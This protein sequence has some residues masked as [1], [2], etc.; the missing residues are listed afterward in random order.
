[1]LACHRGNT[2]CIDVLL[3]DGR[4]EINQK[5]GRGTALHIVAHKAR[6]LL[7]RKLLD[8]GA[9]P[10]L[11]DAQGRIPLEVTNCME[12]AE[13]IPRFVGEKLMQQMGVKETKEVPFASEINTEMDREIQ[14]RFLVLDTAMS[15]LQC[16][17][18]SDDYNAGVQPHLRVSF[19]SILSLETDST[20]RLTVT[21]NS[22]SLVCLGPAEQ[23][24]EWQSR[25]AVHVPGYQGW[26]QSGE[27]PDTPGVH[28]DNPYLSPGLSRE[29]V[30]DLAACGF[31]VL[32]EI[33]SGSFG[34]VYKIKPKSHSHLFALKCLKKAV[35][36][37]HDQLTY[38]IEENKILKTLNHPYIVRHYHS[39]Q[40]PKLLCLVMEYC[41][42]GDLAAH[43]AEKGRFTEEDAR[44][45]LGELVL[46]L[47]YLH[48]NNIL[49]R[50][51]KPENVLL[52]AQGHIRLT[53]FGL[54]KSLGSRSAL[55]TFCGSPA[56][57]SPEAIE[58]A[59]TGK[60]ADIYSLGVLLYE[61]LTG[62][63]PFFS[64]NLSEMFHN[65]TTQQVPIPDSVSPVVTH[66]LQR[67]L[68]RN[69]ASRP[70]LSNIKKDAFF[71][72][73]DWKR[74]ANRRIPPPRLSRFWEQ[75]DCAEAL[76]PLPRSFW[77]TVR[78]YN[79]SSSFEECVLDFD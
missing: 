75:V 6:P 68:S 47:D 61:M 67:L 14:K 18:C 40:T 59:G 57:L 63:T 8:K 58:H 76:S 53:D 41:P 33:G 45:Y 60:P 4:V 56:Y 15:Q 10:S 22:G 64:Y 36:Q 52:D 2:A 19:E 38:A 49:Y 42:N 29:L 54:A 11:T 30:S 79:R 12:I 72:G 26:E 66:L 34:K 74:L 77:E 78:G 50:D 1:M 25:L 51:L 65:I 73:F 23:L 48:S 69:P 28:C 71:K 13:L 37:R 5:T 31:E 62:E 24:R 21:W 46:A 9:D 32:E 70:T 55:S 39:F 43:I 20:N 27:E 16:F 44:I 3:A 35:L 17:G 7:C